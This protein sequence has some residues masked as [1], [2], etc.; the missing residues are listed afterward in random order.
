MSNRKTKPININ[1]F[2]IAAQLKDSLNNIDDESSITKKSE[3]NPRHLKAPRLAKES[4]NWDPNWSKMYP[5]VYRGE[6]SLNKFMICRWCKEAGKNNNFTKSCKYFKKQYLDHH[7]NINNHKMVYAAQIQSQAT[8]HTSFAIQARTDQIKVMR[9][10]RNMYFLIQHNL[11]ANIFESLCKLFEIQHAED[12]GQFECGIETLNIFDNNEFA[13][14]DERAPYSSYQNNVSAHE[15]IKSIG[16]V[17]EQETF[18][19]LCTSDG[20]SIIIDEIAEI[21]Q[22][23]QAKN[24]SY[25]DLMHICS[26]GAS[27]IT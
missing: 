13:D 9:N 1:L 20:W 3:N 26:D 19:E 5:W 23:F 18:Q 24:I 2:T 16:H 21:H 6:G 27:T 15:F 10:M 12:Q 17:V 7:V 8:L 22:F 4:L 14:E 25:N 11:S